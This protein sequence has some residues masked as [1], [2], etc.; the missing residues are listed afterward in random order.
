MRRKLQ[1]ISVTGGVERSFGEALVPDSALFD[2]ALHVSGWTIVIEF[3]PH[4]PTGYD[5]GVA[6]LRPMMGRLER[7]RDPA[8]LCDVA[9]RQLKTLLGFDR[10][11]VYRFRPD[12]TGEVFAE[13]REMRLE[14]FFGLHYPASDI[15]AQGAQAVPDQ[16]PADHQRHCRSDRGNRARRQ[17]S[18][19]SP[20]SEPQHAAQRLA[21]PHRVLA[22]HGRNR[23]DV[24]LDRRARQAVGAVRLPP[25]LRIAGAALFAAHRGGTLRPAV[26]APA[27]AGR[28]RHRP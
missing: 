5:H 24:G 12:D 14:S 7:A 21:D 20:R 17:P 28:I 11:M 8:R 25:L 16:Y 22:Q 15:P 6:M 27:W 13:A 23:V 9:A 1:A 18:G 2:I 3:E 4:T 10:V 19:G 26:R